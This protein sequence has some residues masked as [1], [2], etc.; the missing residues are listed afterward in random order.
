MRSLTKQLIEQVQT[1]THFQV[2]DLEVT[3]Y[4]QG[5]RVTGVSQT[6]YVK[7]LATQAV[8]E[9]LSS[10]TLTNAIEVYC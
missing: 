2:R 5:V 6:Y 3:C 9:E 10:E 4:G 1:L 7:Q 8:L